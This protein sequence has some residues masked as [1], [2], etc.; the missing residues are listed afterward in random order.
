MFPGVLGRG[1]GNQ[2]ACFP[3]KPQRRLRK[4]DLRAE[5]GQRHLCARGRDG[6]R[7]REAEREDEKPVRN[8][9]PLRYHV[10]RLPSN[11]SFAEPVTLR[12]SSL[13]EP[14]KPITRWQRRIRGAETQ[15]DIEVRPRGSPRRSGDCADT[16]HAPLSSHLRPER[17]LALMLSNKQEAGETLKDSGFCKKPSPEAVIT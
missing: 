8:M 17:R 1:R 12:R 9:S 5:C 10:L 3:S 4:L 7:E 14:S 2:F 13:E 15:N 16:L 6:Q 11:L